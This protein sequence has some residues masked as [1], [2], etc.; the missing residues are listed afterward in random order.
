MSDIIDHVA[1]R[2]SSLT[3]SRESYEAALAGPR[4]AAGDSRPPN[5]MLIV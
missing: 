5:A 2:V 1:I 3:R 4:V